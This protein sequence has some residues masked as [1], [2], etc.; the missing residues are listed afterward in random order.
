MIFLQ[1]CRGPIKRS[2]L[3]LALSRHILILE[4]EYLEGNRLQKHTV[5]SIDSSYEAYRNTCLKRTQAKTAVSSY[6]PS[7]SE[8]NSN[9]NT[10]L[11]LRTGILLSSSFGQFSSDFV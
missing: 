4:K 11:N 5:T 1:N 8:T 10:T 3:F 6:D 7:L 9:I 2:T